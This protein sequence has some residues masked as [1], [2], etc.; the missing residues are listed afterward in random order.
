MKNSINQPTQPNQPNQ[1]SIPEFR[2]KLKSSNYAHSFLENHELIKQDILKTMIALKKISDKDDF[3]ITRFLDYI[4]HI[5][6]SNAKLFNQ[7]SISI[8][9]LTIDNKFLRFETRIRTILKILKG[10]ND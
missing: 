9:R 2:Y 6:D 8:N 3:Y 5:L 1:K 7:L 4:G 10:I